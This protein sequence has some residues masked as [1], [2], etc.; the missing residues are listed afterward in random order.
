MPQTCGNDKVFPVP[1]RSG[2]GKASSGLSVNVDSMFRHK[3]LQLISECVQKLTTTASTLDVYSLRLQAYRYL[4][5]TPA[6]SS[7]CAVHNKQAEGLVCFIVGILCQ[8]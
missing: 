5:L 3:F 2:T 6:N 4:Q 7:L 8:I 1:A